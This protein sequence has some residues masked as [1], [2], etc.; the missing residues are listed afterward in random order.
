MPTFEDFVLRQLKNSEFVFGHNTKNL[1]KTLV[2][3]FELI[4]SNGFKII[5]FFDRVGF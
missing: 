2:G 3:N 1:A 5:E 4:S